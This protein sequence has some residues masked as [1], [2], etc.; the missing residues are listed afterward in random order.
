MRAKANEIADDIEI[1]SRALGRGRFPLQLV[2]I[3]RLLV[4]PPPE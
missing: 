2:E 1:S 3:I 4:R